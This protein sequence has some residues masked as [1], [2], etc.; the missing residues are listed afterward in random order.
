MSVSLGSA[1]P[2]LRKPFAP[3]GLMHIERYPVISTKM[4]FN[5]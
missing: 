3:L 1:R 5:N 2:N 4:P